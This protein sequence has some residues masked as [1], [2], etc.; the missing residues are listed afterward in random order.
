VMREYRL[1]TLPVVERKDSR[2]LAGCLR[3]RRLMA[4]VLKEARV[5]KAGAGQGGVISSQ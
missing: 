4:F 3:V 5:T 2:K 1:K